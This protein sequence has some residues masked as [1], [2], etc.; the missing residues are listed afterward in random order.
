MKGL[1]DDTDKVLIVDDL[2]ATGGSLK[3]ACE[4]VEQA[5]AQVAGCIVMLAVDDQSLVKQ[6]F[7]K[8]DGYS[9]SIVIT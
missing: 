8:L 1:I 4:L 7:E 2:I 9:L 5:G 6:A 3:A